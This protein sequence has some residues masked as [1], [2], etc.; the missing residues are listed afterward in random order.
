MTISASP[1]TLRISPY[2]RISD[3]DEERAPGIDRQLRVILPLIEGHDAVATRQYIDNNKSAFDPDVY[4][5]DFEQWLQDFEADLTDGVVAYHL[6]R[7][8][9]QPIDLERIIQAYVRR[10]KRDGRKGVFLFPSGSID[11]TNS[12][13]QMYAR[14]LVT[15]ANKSSSDTVRR[16]TDFYRDEAIKG[17]VYSNYPA[18]Y[19]N[20]DGTINHEQALI[21]LEAI[22]GVLYKGKRPS[23]IAAEWRKQGITTARGGAVTQSTVHRILTSP[24]IA[25]LAV[26]KQEILLNDDGQPIRRKDGGLVDEAVWHELCAKLATNPGF[27]SRGTKG[28]LSKKL[29]CGAC[30]A[31]MVRQQKKRKNG[32]TWFAYNC[33]SVDAGGCAKVAISG[34]KTDQLVTEWVLDFLKQPVEVEEKP[35]SGQARLDEVTAKIAELMGQYRKGELSGSIVF[36]SI[37]QLEDEQKVLRREAAK[38]NRAQTKIT[39]TAEEWPNLGIDQQQAIID[40]IFETIVIMP[41]KKA[42]GAGYDPERVKPEYRKLDRKELYEALALLL[43][44]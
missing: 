30:G 11:L 44:T 24:G 34:P 16:V 3:T 4:R 5:D 31:G 23:T 19:R 28:L 36:P 2:A 18:F 26:Y 32:G 37:K 10:Y 35:F 29:R 20:P 27:R 22:D 25:G 33:R 43:A 39:S 41:A 1:V 6:D 38:H 9:R 7:V 42:R 17:K 14:M 40:M 8:C 15:M 12:D 21:T 13:G